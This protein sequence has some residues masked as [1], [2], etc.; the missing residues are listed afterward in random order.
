MISLGG[1]HGWSEKRDMGGFRIMW[2]RI[3]LLLPWIVNI[4]FHAAALPCFLP[5]V[6][7]LRLPGLRMTCPVRR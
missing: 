1:S 6:S 7:C 3:L 5:D 2:L 4:L